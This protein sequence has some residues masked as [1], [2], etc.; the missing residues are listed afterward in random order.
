MVL[1]R[2]DDVSNSYH[3]VI[4]QQRYAIL[5]WPLLVSIN[6][7]S[8][9]MQ[10]DC[11]QCAKVNV[12]SL[13]DIECWQ[14]VPCTPMFDHITGAH[15]LVSGQSES[16]VKNSLRT[17]KAFVFNDLVFLAEH[18]RVVDN[19]KN[20]SRQHL[21][22]ALADFFAQGDQDFIDTVTGS[23][24][25]EQEEDLTVTGEDDLID[26]LLKGL[27]QSDQQDFQ[28]LKP[29]DG[30]EKAAEVAQWRKWYAEKVEETKV[31]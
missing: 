2:F 25:K 15:L 17:P 9:Q 7:E 26:Q 21:L 12:I 28:S 8:V 19:A 13:Y 5:T 4:S 29:K 18:F 10:L 20:K 11:S 27:E 6:H 14:C 16:I 1:K 31:S 22:S 24:Q 23:L 3:L 30:K